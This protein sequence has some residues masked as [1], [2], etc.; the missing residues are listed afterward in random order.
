[1]SQHPDGREDT[2]TRGI[3]LGLALVFAAFTVG[4]IVYTL[5]R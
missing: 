4:A 2:V 3:L 5:I 1:M